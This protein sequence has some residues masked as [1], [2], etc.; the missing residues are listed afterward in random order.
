MRA[1]QINRGATWGLI[2]LSLTAFITVLP[3][4]LRG[5]LGGNLPPA[6][7]D[8]GTAAHIFQLSIVA[9]LPTA[10]MFLATADWTRPWR[11]VRTLVVPAAAVVAAFALLYYIEHYYPSHHPG[12]AGIVRAPSAAVR[13]VGS[14]FTGWIVSIR[15]Y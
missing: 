5:L 12:A 9:L 1:Q 6:E 8:E 15:T 4:A 7:A 3:V 11:I 14:P 10:L 2:L 13:A